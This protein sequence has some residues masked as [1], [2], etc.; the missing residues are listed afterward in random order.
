MTRILGIDP[1]SRVT[2][3][4]IIDVVKQR[5]IYIDSGCIRTDTDR[6]PER[7]KIIFSGINDVVGHYEPDEMA[8]ENVFMQRNVDSALKLGQ[9]R[10]AAICAVVTNSVPVH[11][12]TPA[13]IKQAIVGKGNAEKTQ[14]QHMV[15]ALL[16]LTQSPQSDAADALACALCHCHTRQT[17]TQMKQNQT[18]FRSLH[19]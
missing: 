2:G 4:G 14:V 1:G 11:E 10:G 6:L 19:P 12:Y 9:A 17:L 7:L 13:Q 16:S 15:K 8:I 18:S 3:F 5:T